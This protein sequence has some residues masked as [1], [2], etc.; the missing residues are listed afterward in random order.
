MRPFTHP[1]SRALGAAVAASTVL[2]LG[3]GAAQAA[4]P[5]GE[6]EIAPGNKICKNQS[7]TSWNGRTS[8]KVTS[9]GSL[10]V[11]KDGRT[12][13]TAPG[14][15]GKGQC[16]VYTETGDLVVTNAANSAV[17][18]AGTAHTYGWIQVQNDGNVVVHGFYGN[19]VW[20]SA[21]HD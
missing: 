10:T 5:S 15:A 18:S 3:G 2:V 11:V 17:W 12:A 7:W 20:H 19:P 9:T 6:F 13:W 4:T 16:A 21:T 8:L 14:T 1:L